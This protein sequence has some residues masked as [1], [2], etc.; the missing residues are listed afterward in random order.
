M[1]ISNFK[2][3]II[4]REV[5]LGRHTRCDP[6]PQMSQFA[7]PATITL[8]ARL[9]PACLTFQDHHI[10]HKLHRN[11]KPFGRSAM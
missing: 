10:V 9:Q 8:L 5:G 2:H 7:V 1:R 3:Q 4:Q 11:P 6:V